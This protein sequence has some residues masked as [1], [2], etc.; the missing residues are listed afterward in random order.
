MYH[1]AILK[2]QFLN[3]ILAGT[4]TIESRFSFNKIA[5][6]NKVSVN[7]TIYFKESGGQVVAKAKIKDVKYYQLTPSIVEDIRVKYG[8][9]I[10]TDYFE[11]WKTTLTKKY[12]TLIWLEDV[13]KL[14]PFTVPRSNGTAWFVL[15]KPLIN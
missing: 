4:K 1:L 11:D 5:P 9:N 6:Y 2:N 12:C 10:G 13:E 15:D 3:M 7:D 8:K 14:T